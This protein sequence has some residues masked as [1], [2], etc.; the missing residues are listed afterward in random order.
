MKKS[1]VS[2][3]ALNRA[4]RNELLNLGVPEYLKGYEYLVDSIAIAVCDRSALRKIT[5]C[6]Y[7]EVAQD[8]E[9]TSASVERAITEKT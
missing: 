2:N 1:F 6:V 5:Q 8:Y 3:P 9:A 4:I 7:P